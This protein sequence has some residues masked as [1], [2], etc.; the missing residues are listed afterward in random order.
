MTNVSSEHSSIEIVDYQVSV[1]LPVTK[2]N[3]DECVFF[4]ENDKIVTSDWKESTYGRVET[5]SFKGEKI[6][7]MSQFQKP[8]KQHRW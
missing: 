2:E 5:F 7:H 3:G 8:L 6:I 4:W 1:N